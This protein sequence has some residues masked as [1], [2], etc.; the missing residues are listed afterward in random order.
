MKGN[1]VHI[2]AN[3]A[4]FAPE[5]AHMMEAIL[6]DET[7]FTESMTVM[8]PRGVVLTRWEVQK[9]IKGSKPNLRSPK[10]FQVEKVILPNGKKIYRI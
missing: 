2:T 5:E 7:T 6:F 1:T 4:P 8:R 3:R 10:K 9:S